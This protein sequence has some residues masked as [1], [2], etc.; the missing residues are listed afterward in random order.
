MG[1][2]AAGSGA[3]HCPEEEVTG[4]CR[5]FDAVTAWRVFS[6]PRHARDAP[7]TAAKEAR[8]KD[9]MAV[10]EE[11]TEAERRRPG[12]RSS[13]VLLA[14]ASEEAPGAA[15]ERD[16]V[17]GVQAAADDGALPAVATRPPDYSALP[18]RPLHPRA[19]E[20]LWQ[21]CASSAENNVW[22]RQPRL[23]NS[24]RQACRVSRQRD[25]DS[26]RLRY[27]RL[28]V[29]VQ[30]SSDVRLKITRQASK[31]PEPAQCVSP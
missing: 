20:P 4:K 24:L 16:A 26:L 6:L 15:G 17:A 1:R 28:A 12:I 10:I 13:V 29:V 30:R 3:N 23:G 25:D 31:Q 14:R 27:N 19:P 2:G 21:D 5:V 8:T 9:G 11:V 18:T 7:E 22:T